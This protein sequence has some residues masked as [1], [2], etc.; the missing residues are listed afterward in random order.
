[1]TGG[2]NDDA[3]IG[4]TG[5]DTITFGGGSN[6]RAVYAESGSANVDTIIDYHATS[7]DVIDLSQ[8]L[9]ANFGPSSNVADFVRATQSGSDVIVQVDPD[10]AANG[11]NFSD[12]T[13]LSGYGTANPD[14]VLV[15][16]DG[17]NHTLTA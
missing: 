12:V 11:A 1:M 4:G 17:A 10:G 7:N 8:L 3:M 16:F 2:G 6:N 5:N 14:S 9:D 13:R 15:Y